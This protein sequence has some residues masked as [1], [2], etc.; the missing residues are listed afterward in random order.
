MS[1]SHRHNCRRSQGAASAVSFALL[2]L[3]VSP[4]V[5][6]ATTATT[7]AVSASQI[8]NL[9][10][11][12]VLVL[13]AFFAVAWLLKR[14]SGLQGVNKGHMK[15]VDAMHLGTKERL[16]IVKVANQNLLLGI[17]PQGIHPLHVFSGDLIDG[18]IVEHPE[19]VPGFNQLL[20]KFKLK[21]A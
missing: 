11:G 1:S 7:G 17:S 14:L 13:L 8:V 3:S 18:N 21:G 6:A 20:S 12:L 2:Q 9:V 15:I 16:L 5:A 10:A 4:M 19:A